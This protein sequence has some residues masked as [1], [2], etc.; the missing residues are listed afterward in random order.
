MAKKGFF[1]KLAEDITVFNGEQ[2]PEAKPEK[3]ESKSGTQTDTKPEPESKP[4]TKP[5]PESKLEQTE[6]KSEPEQ[7]TKPDQKP[8]PESKPDVP[9]EPIPD[10]P[11]RMVGY[12]HDQNIVVNG[13]VEVTNYNY[14]GKNAEKPERPDPFAKAIAE[15]AFSFDEEKG[16]TDG[17]AL[18]ELKRARSEG[19]IPG[20]AKK[21]AELVFLKSPKERAKFIRKYISEALDADA[22][23]LTFIKEIEARKHQI[24]RR[25]KP[26]NPAVGEL[27]EEDSAKTYIDGQKVNLPASLAGKAED[28]DFGRWVFVEYN[29]DTGEVRELTPAEAKPHEEAWA[30]AHQQP[31]GKPVAAAPSKK[32][33]KAG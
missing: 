18:Y 12:N 19:E 24:E 7:D 21:F 13:T 11:T 32:G 17:S 14:G 1:A 9:A 31:Q 6:S 23:L 33:G 28:S 3:E 30:K 27:L 2:E 25:F 15:L 26:D 20:S 22:E 5:E 10:N 29:S 4:D 8:E 16:F